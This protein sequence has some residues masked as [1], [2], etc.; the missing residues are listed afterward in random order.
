MFEHLRYET[1]QTAQRVA[2][3]GFGTLMALTGVGFLSASALMLLLTLT[4]AITAC[5]I[6]GGAF[7]GVGLLIAYTAKPSNFAAAPLHEQAQQDAMPPIAA[8]FMQGLAQGMSAR[9]SQRR[10]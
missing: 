6:M 10:S 9:Q 8:A 3:G 7:V 5:A 1:R 2:L 4:D